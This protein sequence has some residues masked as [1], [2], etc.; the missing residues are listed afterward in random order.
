MNEFV[1]FTSLWG[2]SLPNMV[3]KIRQVRVDLAPAKPPSPQV[4]SSQILSAKCKTSILSP[5]EYNFANE[6]HYLSSVE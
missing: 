2:C 4:K 5:I 1:G 3:L 6:V